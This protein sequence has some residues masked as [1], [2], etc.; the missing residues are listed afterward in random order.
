VI[1]LD[2]PLL[3]LLVPL[4][5]ACQADD[6][7]T[8]D[9]DTD[10]AVGEN[11]AP[12]KPEV[13]ITPGDAVTGTGLTAT[14]EAADADGDD[15]TYTVKWTVDAEGVAFDPRADGIPA[16]VVARDQTWTVLVVARDGKSA[17]KP[18]KASITIGNA[19]PV[20]DAFT[21]GPAA[22]R[23]NDTL[24][25]S[26]S[27][28]DPEGDR[29]V[30]SYA[31]K[32]NGSVVLSGKGADALAP[33]DDFAKGDT[34]V[35]TLALD[36]GHGGTVQRDSDPIVI[37]NVPPGPPSVRMSPRLAQVRD[38]LSC[39]I[40]AA[41][42]DPD[43]DALTYAITWLRDGTPVSTVTATPGQPVTQAA[44]AGSVWTCTA[45]ANDGTDD[46]LPAYAS[47]TLGAPAPDVANLSLGA[48]FSC[49]ARADGH[50]A[51]WGLDGNADGTG[52]VSSVNGR[53]HPPDVD[54]TAL[55]AASGWACGVRED[56][57]GLTCWGAPQ[58]AA[59]PP[60]G[61]FARID[62]A[63]DYA[64]A[65]Q[66]DS[67]LTCWKRGVATLGAALTPPEGGWR[68]FGVGS[69]HGCAVA[70]DG[71][72]TC[73]GT[74]G[75]PTLDAPEGTFLTLSAN[76]GHTCALAEDRTLV[77]W[78]DTTYGQTA[79]PTGTFRAVAAG[80]THTC[81]IADDGTLACWGDDTYGQASPPEGTFEDVW[82]GVTHSCARDGDGAIVC[83][84]ESTGGLL[85][86]PW[87]RVASIDVGSY[88]VC[89]VDD[90]GLARCWGAGIEAGD[91]GAPLADFVSVD[92]NTTH[93]CG[94]TTGGEVLC[95]GSN[96]FGET[97]PPAGGTWDDVATGFDFS[98]GIHSGS[99]QVECWGNPGAGAPP[100]GTKL[101]NEPTDRA[102]QVSCGGTFA[103]I[104][105]LDGTVDC[106]GTLG[107]NTNQVL[108]QISSGSTYSCGLL[109][110]G[111][112]KCWGA[113]APRAKTGP[114]QSISVG[115]NYVCALGVDGSIDCWGGLLPLSP[116]PKP[117]VT[118]FVDLS[119]GDQ[120]LCALDADGRTW[121]WGAWGREPLDADL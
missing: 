48:G 26:G 18:G 81:A 52:I 90:A 61:V 73:W 76:G 80:A 116:L 3:A 82:A 104:L 68:T 13:T 94:L 108:T 107:G 67:T 4:V 8:D 20:V 84:G 54:F 86:V 44:N 29:V 119:V 42:V 69:G 47:I 9:T 113:L 1:R 10:V 87:G 95:W 96:D 120:A 31:W 64:C 2:R 55:A 14:Y 115:S 7:G 37:G 51:C 117:D 85:E 22:P 35:V 112:S 36:D 58:G 57:G 77:C 102:S 66:I 38:T 39:T 93:A 88:D 118:G 106:W 16:D 105:K 121:C 33:G 49:A 40:D 6:P 41:A 109:A 46:S 111:S 71:S 92:L 45:R 72:I 15:L 89:V 43:G 12:G 28:S 99:Q 91:T 53:T 70:T 98:C 83:W 79:A 50:T 30:A 34:V 59:N 65:Q 78:G 75:S 5:V 32:V 100:L 103:C 60:D 25:A 56:D 97:T 23:A 74:P 110:D 21:W 27:G 24:V 63:G 11:H 19:P 114:Y 17:G 62:A 101:T